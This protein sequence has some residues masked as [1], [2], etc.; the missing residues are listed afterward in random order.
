VH[1]TP[2]RADAIAVL[3]L[4]NLTGDVAQQFFVDGMH[5]ALIANLS[6]ISA[7][8][9]IS[10]TSTRA[11]A[12]SPKS[13]REIAAELGASRVVEGSVS[14]SGDD[15]RITVQLIDARTDTH[16]WGGVFD[17]DLVNVLRLQWDVA[18][19]IVAEMRVVL[20]PSEATRLASA[21]RVHPEAYEAYLKGTYHWYRLTP[22]DL[23]LALRF[24]DAALAADP[25]YAP[26]HAGVAIA[27]AGLQQ[28]GAVPTRVAGPKIKA[29]LDKALD[30]DANLAQAHFTLAAYYTWAAWD[31]AMAEPSFL[32]AIELNP[33]FPDAH[34]YYAHYLNIVGRFDEADVAIGCALDLDPFNPLIRSLYVV[35]LMFRERY[36]E[37]IAETQSV[38]NVA[39]NHWLAF[40]AIRFV[41][42]NRHMHAEALDATRSLFATLGNR[43][44]VDALDRGR[45]EGDYRHAMSGAADA[46]ALQAKTGYVM[47]TQIAVLYGMADDVDRAVAWLEAAFQSR[48]PGLPYLKNLRRFPMAVM[49]D[50]RTRRII[51]DLGYPPSPSVP[52]GN[53]SS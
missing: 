8:K 29:A 44:V 48:D 17:R 9:V 50:Q 21:P 42:H 35:C 14:R 30:L 43:A 40:E 25:D 18:R 10:R 38:L 26:A 36:D 11:Y 13:L 4:E 47:P 32:R 34:A 7:L 53:R 31:L 37:A 49:D 22:E 19:A 41:Y 39:P 5:E 51:A 12:G 16:L 2:A 33:N 24:F 3:P 52:V 28:M 46:L 1:S 27:W 45:S 23:R 6:K 20:T 15:A